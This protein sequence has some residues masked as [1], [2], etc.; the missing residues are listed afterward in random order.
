MLV[1][2]TLL[3]LDIAKMPYNYTPREYA[4]MHFIYGLC[5]GNARQAARTYRERYP[6]RERY[7]DY[8]VFLRVN[9]A[10]LEGRIPGAATSEGRPRIVDE[11]QVLREVERDPS[12]SVRRISRR[13]RVARSSA[14]RILKR[15]NLHPYHVQRVQSLLP[16]DYQRRVDFCREMLRRC[17]ENQLYFNSILWSDESSFK[18][19]GVFNMHNLHYWSREN[20]QIVREDRFQHQF[21]V[22]LWAGILDGRVIGP[23]ELPS[24]LNGVRYLDF[25]RN[26]LNN[27]LEEVPQEVRE[28]MWLQ[29]DGAPAHYSRQVI[30]YLN[31]TYPNRWIG[32]AGTIPW[33]PRS[34]DL[35]PIDYFLWGYFKEAVYETSN[36]N[37]RQLRQKLNIVAERVK[38]NQLALRSLRRNFIRRCWLC[39]RVGGRHFEHLL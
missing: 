14:H 12:T 5:D 37:E 38:N 23:F 7:P 36:N 8:R 33:P 13:T 30:N 1:I 39:I 21:G 22:N 18:R 15:N 9:N 26:D 31:V 27:L 10:Y 17:R 4:E 3:D 32:R 34:P 20:P 2:W 6:N 19:V 11:R 29:H 25:L 16:S 24:R 35:N 28:R